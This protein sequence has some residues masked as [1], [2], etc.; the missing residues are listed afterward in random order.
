MNTAE[1]EKKRGVMGENCGKNAAER[2]RHNSLYGTVPCDRGAPPK[3]TVHYTT[4]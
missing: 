3:H 4:E 2:T 1:K